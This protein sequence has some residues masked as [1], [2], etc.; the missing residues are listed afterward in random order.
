[1]GRVVLV[2]RLAARDLRR[3]PAEAALLLLA[4]A[5]ATTARSDRQGGR[6]SEP[7]GLEG[8]SPGL[9]TCG[10]ASPTPRARSG[11]PSG[12]GRVVSETP[13]E[14]RGGADRPPSLRSPAAER[15][16]DRAQARQRAL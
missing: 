9:P 3:R 2:C 16:R 13:P 14:G 11:L 6:V 12:L 15:G 4:I 7:E 8:V 10:S 1:M 5:A